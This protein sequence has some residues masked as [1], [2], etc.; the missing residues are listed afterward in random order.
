[1]TRIDSHVHFWRIDHYASGWMQGPFAPLKRNFLPRDLAPLMRERGIERAVFVQAQHVE[2]DNQWVLDLAR[3]HPW[4]AGV[5][6][7]IDLRAPDV[8]ERVAHWSAQPKFCG[9]RHIVQ[10]EPDDDWILRDDVS[11]G[12]RALE[13]HD[14][15]YDLLFFVKH[16]RHA[17]TVA[18]RFPRLRLVID[19]C[20][21]PRI[22]AGSVDD[23][24]PALREAA[25]MPNVFIKL[26]GLVT[27]ADWHKW[28]VDDLRRYVDHALQCFGP[29]R[30]MLGSDWPVCTLAGSYARVIEALDAT[31]GRLSPSEKAAV[32]GETAARFYRLRD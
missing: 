28:T 7:W 17:A 20:S 13:E 15:A 11:R 24:L 21:K 32:Q 16:L 8:A 26:S 27:E 14:V 2:A 25:R 3:E 19:H 4:I 31:L 1:M 10:D 22:A 5:V 6:G 12:L 9:V 23:W 29:A 18:K 30:A